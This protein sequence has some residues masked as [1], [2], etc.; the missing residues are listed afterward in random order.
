MNR[1]IFIERIHRSLDNI[2]MSFDSQ[3]RAAE[4]AKLFQLP[5]STSRAILSGATFP[6]DEL[7]N[8]IAEELEVD[9]TWLLG[10]DA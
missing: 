8:K 7:L 2:E 6:S 4:F 3:E 5:L 10:K 9:K 1:S